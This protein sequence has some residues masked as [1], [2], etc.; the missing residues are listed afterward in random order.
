MNLMNLLLLLT[1]REVIETAQKCPRKNRCHR[2]LYAQI[3]SEL[4]VDLFFKKRS[5]ANIEEIDKKSRTDYAN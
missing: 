3:P 4:K 5:R 2:I 1:G